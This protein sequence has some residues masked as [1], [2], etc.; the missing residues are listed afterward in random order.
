MKTIGV[1]RLKANLSRYLDI[2][3]H[4]Q[5]IVVTDRGVAIA[6]IVPLA[7]SEREESQRQ[8][9]VKAGLLRPGSGRARFARFKVPKGPRG[10]YGVLK[11]LLEEREEGR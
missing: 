9:L 7:P 5:E 1:A 3:K 2:V 8:R 10:G 4:G 6:K 11:A